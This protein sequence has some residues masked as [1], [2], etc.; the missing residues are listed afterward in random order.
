ME[1]NEIAQIRSLIEQIE[2]EDLS[3]LIKEKDGTNIIQRLTASELISII[4]E[5]I[6]A[7]K[8]ADELNILY[9]CSRYFIRRENQGDD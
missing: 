6:T 3:F 5:S 9:A 2:S 4:Q 1:A 8:E 7:V